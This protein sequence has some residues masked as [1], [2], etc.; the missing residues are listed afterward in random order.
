MLNRENFNIKSLSYNEYSYA[1][2]GT[3]FY[4]TYQP[5]GSSILY[6]D[7]FETDGTKTIEVKD[8]NAF[9]E[10]IYN[11]IKDWKRNYKP[12]EQIF[13]SLYWDLKVELQDETSYRFKG[14]HEIPENFEEFPFKRFC[15]V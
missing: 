14:Y 8:E 11:L 3:K 15:R 5:N 9:N 12:H 6:S 2:P 10:Q 1:N 7:F 4:Y 13:D